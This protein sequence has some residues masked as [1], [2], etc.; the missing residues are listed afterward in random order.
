MEVEELARPVQIRSPEDPTPAEVEEHESTG[1]VQ[2]RTWCKH[3]VAGR[4]VGQQHRTR[5]E[6]ARAQDGIPMISC[7]YT[8]MTV[9]GEEDGRAK[10]ILVIKDS[11][12]TSVA[13]TF[14]DAKGP[15]PYAVKYFSNFLKTL[16]YKRVLLQSDGE[17]SIVALKTQ[18]ATAAGVEGVPR[19]SPRGE[20]QANGL[21]EQ[22]C[23]E[24]KMHI[25]VGR[26]A[27]EEKLGQPLGDTDPLLAW[28]PRHVGDLLNRYRKGRDG[29]TP[30]QRRSGKQWRKPAIAFGER[31]YYR[32]VGEGRRPL[33]VGRYIGHHGRTGT[34]LVMTDSGVMRGTGIRR[35]GPTDQW[36]TEDL[37]QLRGLP[38]EVTARRPA[39]R[40]EALIGEGRL[41][42]PDLPQRVA[43]APPAQRRIYIRKE[44]VNKYGSTEGCP[45]CTCVL[46]DGPT[47]VPHTE[48]CRARIIGQMMGDETGKERLEAY[49][50]RRKR[51]K[52]APV[53]AEQ[54]VAAPEAAGE[55]TAVAIEEPQDPIYPEDPEIRERLKRAVETRPTG[56]ESGGKPKARTAP[57]QAVK[58]PGEL[59]IGAGPAMAKPKIQPSQG[60]KRAAETAVE[61]LRE[62]AGEAPTS[63]PE[64]MEQGEDASAFS[65][66]KKVLKTL[67]K[68]QVLDAYELHGLTISSEEADSIADLS[69]QMCAVD[70]MEIYSPKRFT[71]TAKAFKLRPGF[72][73][74]LTEQKPDGSYWDLNK[75]EDVKEVEETID[76][77][78]P[79]LLTGSPP[80]HMFSQLQNISWHKLSPEIREK[81]MSE[82]LHHLHVS[83]KMY[84]KQYDS[85]RWFLHEAPWGAASWKDPQVQAILALPG[86]Y[87]V[88]GPMCRWEMK[89]TDRRGLQGHGYVRKE[90]GW[91]TNNERLASLLK[92][93]CTNQQGKD[94]H[95]HIHLIGGI[96]RQAA[97]YPPKL[98]RAVLKC[99]R[100]QLTESGELS[101]AE[102]N[103]SGPVPEEP[104]I[105]PQQFEEWYWDDVNGGWLDSE[106]VKE[107][108]KLEMEYLKKQAVYEKRPMSEALKVTG[109]RPIPVRWLDTDKGDPTKP[110]FRS[111]LVVK[112]IK[113]AKSE[114]EQLPQNLL[115][116]STPPL[117]SMRLLC[118]L[119]STQKLSKRGQKL[120][121]GLWDISRAHFYGIP[122][123]TIYIELPD[124]DASY[125]ESGE[126]E[127]GLLMK[128]MYGTQD[129]PNIWQ[130]HYTGLL[131]SV[132]ICRGKSNASVFYRDRDGIRIVVHGDDFL[133]LGDD[134]GLQE[135]DDLLRSTYELKRLG[136][137]GFDEGDDKEIHFLN[138][139]IRVGTHQGR[140]A[141]FLEPDRRHVDLLIRNLGLENAKGVDTPDLKKPVEQQMLESK[142]TLLTKDLA[143]MFR[144]SVMRAAYLSQD[145]PDLSHAVK[146]L[147]RKMVSPTESSLADLK[148]LGRYLK[149]Y[150]NFAQVFATQAEPTSIKV[151][152][153]S[154]HAGDA[155]TRRSTTGMIALYGT[156]TLKHASNIQST[157]ALSTGESE[158]YAL[159]RGGSTA[160]GLQSLLS[161]LGINL[162][163]TVESDS[164][165]AKGTVSRIGLGKA[166]HIQ[167]RYLWLQERVSM[168]HLKVLHV[169]GKRNRADVFT[170]SVPGV[171]MHK[172]M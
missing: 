50:R 147:S 123:R 152:V 114:S 128:S 57:A 87:L 16:G 156:H 54:D 81:R 100:Q 31:L 28:M 45:G 172:T 30:E 59:K 154:D 46:L 71:D 95:R 106:K 158:Y 139:L 148:R 13:A 40:G 157:I 112:D 76:R 120:K 67:I 78:E 89:A 10:P 84:R 93:E 132:G 83:C 75:S 150:P 162:P 144:S 165:S 138:R 88:K 34:L 15:T 110:N 7:D 99:L 17:H 38:W 73:V 118:S 130:S 125:T 65:K 170:K 121:L 94:W 6:E 169:P 134:Q 167:T 96:A 52:D 60:D 61:D 2:Y 97:Q 149:K 85:G 141:V 1:H 58:R 77:E 8:F 20:H 115:F 36:T 105:D 12:T 82:A 98:V 27:L 142:S 80:C 51:Q 69:C 104:F 5:D 68:R 4:G 86:V 145:R 21:I 26:S 70:V 135:V 159:V 113:A 35:L 119:M 103:V 129:A 25:R 24:I 74:D 143:S 33:K 124:E 23:K 127:C 48:A 18:A 91:L 66:D 151:Q 101:S 41:E 107:A 55:P 29:K 14:V 122:K 136:T 155:V 79:K 22:V 44:D 160:L 111:R 19:E 153:D 62:T 3:C 109:R 39:E 72:A 32:E 146:N 102:A 56:S 163:V 126:K 171:Q 108:R 63:A 140:Q 90:T 164:N 131:E 11:R 43:L 116:S 133:V 42:V 137:L 37:G 161:D 64:P 9:N 47:T 117:E 53:V 168:G 166:R 49:E 92:G